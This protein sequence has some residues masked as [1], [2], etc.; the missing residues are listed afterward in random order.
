MAR[1]GNPVCTA[2]D[3]VVA[4]REWQAPPSGPID[5]STWTSRVA[6]GEADGGGGMHGSPL[7]GAR[8]V[9]DVVTEL[10][11]EVAADAT[12]IAAHDPAID[13]VQFL[14]DIVDACIAVRRVRHDLEGSAHIA[15]P[16]R[17]ERGPW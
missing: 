7:D 1:R 14:S 8:S 4:G 6:I 2:A 13:Q 9:C 16:Q 12:V 11:G 3:D 17:N 15:Q 10:L 5:R